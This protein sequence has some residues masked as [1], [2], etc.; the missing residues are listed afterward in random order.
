MTADPFR[1][2]DEADLQEL[3]RDDMC[4]RTVPQVGTAQYVEGTCG[5]ILEDL[6]TWAKGQMSTGRWRKPVWVLSAPTGSGKS[7]VASKFAEHLHDRGSLGASVFFNAASQDRGSVQRF[8][9]TIAYQLA[10]SQDA[11]RPHIAAAAREHLRNGKNQQMAF[12]CK[13]LLLKPLAQLPEGHS[14]VVIVVDGLDE[15]A[16]NAPGAVTQLLEHLVSC[17]RPP[18]SPVRILMTYR[19]HC[20]AVEE[21]LRDPKMQDIVH[22][23]SLASD[24]G[25]FLNA[26]LAG[27]ACINLNA[28]K[29]IA[30]YAGSSFGYAIAVANFLHA[31][32]GHA[33]DR[34]A[35]VLSLGPCRKELESLYALYPT[36][37]GYAHASRLTVTQ[38][39]KMRTRVERP[40]VFALC[41]SPVC[42]KH[43]TDWLLAPQ[44]DVASA[45]TIPPELLNGLCTD[46]HGVVENKPLEIWVLKKIAGALKTNRVDP[47]DIFPSISSAEASRA[48]GQADAWLP[49]PRAGAGAVRVTPM[50]AQGVKHAKD[51]PQPS[52][53][54]PTTPPPAYEVP[55]DRSAILTP[56]HAAQVSSPADITPSNMHPPSPDTQLVLSGSRTQSRKTLART[57]TLSIQGLPSLNARTSPRTGSPRNSS[58][59]TSSPRSSRFSRTPRTAWTPLVRRNRVALMH[60]LATPIKYA[61]ADPWTDVRRVSTAVSAIAQRGGQWVRLMEDVT[62]GR[63][64]ALGRVGQTGVSRSQGGTPQ[65]VSSMGGE[66]PVGQTNSKRYTM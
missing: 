29:T 54:S 2:E 33:A 24:I 63:P 8:F 58:P 53:P 51:A 6:D 46:C 4:F 9:S 60:I 15:C 42:F 25:V 13:N 17:A 1:S 65:D 39:T 32:P 37:T 11:L 35:I 41:G 31:D 12:D 48:Q 50:H 62:H 45:G 19:S 14:P 21:V 26:R 34:L 66:V 10:N 18:S 44:T 43:V 59:R 30:S 55:A 38:W 5:D 7:T 40:A 52:Q 23:L 3:P 61:V 28:T 16:E 20:D 56:E 27:L 64:P 47:G 36:V 57:L 22:H 49:T